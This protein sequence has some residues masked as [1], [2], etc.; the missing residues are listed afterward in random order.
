MQ[1]NASAS[2][3]RD[4]T[5]RAVPAD[6]DAAHDAPDDSGDEA[7]GRQLAAREASGVHASFAMDLAPRPDVAAAMRQGIAFSP[8]A[9]LE[10]NTSQDSLVVGTVEA[11]PWFI[12]P[13]KEIP[14][15]LLLMR[16]LTVEKHRD[17]F[18]HHLAQ[19]FLQECDCLQR[20]AYLTTFPASHAGAVGGGMVAHEHFYYIAMMSTKRYP[21]PMLCCKQYDGSNFLVDRAP[22]A[23]L[24]DVTFDG[25]SSAN[26]DSF[27]ARAGPRGLDAVSADIF[28]EEYDHFVKQRWRERKNHPKLTPNS[29]TKPAI[30][31]RRFSSFGSVMTADG[32]GKSLFEAFR[33][34]GKWLR[35]RALARSKRREQKTGG[36]V[37]TAGNFRSLQAQK[38]APYSDSDDSI[39]SNESVL[40]DIRDEVMPTLLETFPFLVGAGGSV[41]TG[42]TRRVLPV[43]CA[44]TLW[45]YNPSSGS[46]QSIDLCAPSY[47]V[48][49]MWVRVMRGVMAINSVT[50]TGD[51]APERPAAADARKALQATA[52]IGVSPGTPSYDKDRKSVV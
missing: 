2:S 42:N 35:E 47:R 40:D 20:G 16:G 8:S 21:Q 39:T 33:S 17:V 7:V 41:S 46:R 23:A 37:G 49:A 36:G 25:F 13:Q 38:S 51:A 24:V 30:H 26:F 28:R 52:S 3:Q 45:F 15:T 43:Q 22:L 11:V 27:H 12:N 10:A 19:S 1:Q 29:S 4:C 5:F 50:T 32:N 31:H 44:F 14:Y 6:V 9:Q 34:P 48:A 18:D